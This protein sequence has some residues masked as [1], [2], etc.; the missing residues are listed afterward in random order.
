MKV[1]MNS[2]ILIGSLV[3]TNRVNSVVIDESWKKVTQTATI[4]LPRLQKLLGDG[5]YKIKVG[6]RVVIQLGYDNILQTE[7]QGYVSSRGFN[8]PLEFMCED[9]MWKQKQR[10]VTNSWPSITLKALLKY[11]IPGVDITH[12]QNIT[13]TPFKLDH[14]TVAD[15]LEKLKDDYGIVAYYRQGS[16]LF[17]GL[18]Y[19]ETGLGKVQYHFQR[20]LPF[21][22]SQLE[23]KESGDVKIKVR[24]ISMLP[25]NKKIEI[26]LGDDT[27]NETTLHFY[28]LTKEELRKQAEEKIKKMKYTGYRGTLKTF[29][30]PRVVHG[31]VAE[32]TN[33]KFQERGGNYIIDGVKTF[34]DNNG[35]SREIELGPKT[36]VAA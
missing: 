2:R 5:N 33:E 31:M 13:L 18:A 17:C 23:F 27:G 34:Y 19:S 9:E 29:G 4:K 36:D 1:K 24:A 28:N 10:T 21:N 3:F 8:S 30:M 7:F 15:A 20:N 26:S 12:V 11:L 14:V 32:L 22:E 25:N 16:P 35:F 6:D